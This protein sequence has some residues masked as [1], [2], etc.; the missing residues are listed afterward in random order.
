MKRFCS[1]FFFLSC[2]G[3]LPLAAQPVIGGNSCNSASLSGIY[4]FTLTG[5]QVT[6]AGNFTNVLQGN[7]SANFDGL[8]KVTITL[9]TDTLQSV[10]TPL[11]WSGT[12]TIQS[13]CAG[14]VTITSGGS[15]TLNLASYDQ[16][17]DFLVTGNDA[18]YSYS[19]SGNTQPTG[20]SAATL[21]GVYVFTG[22]GYTVSNGAVNG[23][24]SSSGL[25]QFDGVSNV[26]VNLTISGSGN[27]TTVGT[28][29]G[30]YSISGTCVGSA[31]L[32][33][34]GGAS[35]VIAFSITNSSVANG[36]FDLAFAETGKL[37]SSGSAHVVYGQPTTTAA[38]RE[39]GAKPA[40]V[41]AKLPMKAV[42]EGK[43]EG[44]I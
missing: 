35:L 32:T 29:T 43:V 17:V 40:E 19:G 26:T 18:T 5:R 9:T 44:K 24:E 37:L 34:A 4:A 14:V 21:S 23:A 36:A 1:K 33:I 13:N 22:T 20:C 28:G 12:Y 10:A 3:A 30:S 25:L 7:G 39:A 31:T 6:S 27:T 2:L 41:L 11:T 8:S 16:G 42:H 15:A 38:N